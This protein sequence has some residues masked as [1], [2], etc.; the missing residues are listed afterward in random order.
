MGQLLIVLTLIKSQRQ[1]QT[2]LI[3]PSPRALTEGPASPSTD[4]FN[5]KRVA[6]TYLI[7]PQDTDDHCTD[8]YNV[9]EIVVGQTYVTQAQYTGRRSS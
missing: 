5:A 4:P 9:T 7:L 8:P 2:K 3:S 1:L 6:V